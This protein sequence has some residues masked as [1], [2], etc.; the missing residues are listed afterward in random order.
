MTEQDYMEVIIS[1]TAVLIAAACRIGGMLGS[2]TMPEQEALKDFG[3]NL[4]IAFQ[5]VDDTLDYTLSREQFGK[6]VGKDVEEGKI[7]LPLIQALDKAP[8]KP[9]AKLKELV[10][11]ENYQPENFP[12]VLDLVQQ[13]GGI[14]SA[15]QKA[16]NYADKAVASLKIF[17]ESEYKLLMLDLADFVVR[18]KL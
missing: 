4:G 16:H 9:R 12:E 11:R 6:P 14:D 2:T 3:L 15:F 1:K 18:R 17:P 13:Y 10:S 5:M 7:T 8:P